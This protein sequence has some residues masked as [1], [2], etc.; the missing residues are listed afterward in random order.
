MLVIRV[1]DRNRISQ[2][3]ANFDYLVLDSGSESVLLMGMVPVEQ[4]I[5]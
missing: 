1:M 5:A 4:L 2:R 3:A